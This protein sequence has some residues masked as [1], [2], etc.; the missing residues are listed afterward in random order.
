VLL[1]RTRASGRDPRR[2]VAPPCRPDPH[3]ACRLG[4]KGHE[5]YQIV[6]DVKH[7]FDDREEIKKRFAL[8]N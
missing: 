3:R 4:G 1:G 8:L 2:R 6:G 7:P 5:T